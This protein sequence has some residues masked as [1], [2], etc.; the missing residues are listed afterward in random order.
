MTVAEL[1]I[2]LRALP[3]ELPAVIE[4]DGRPLEVEGVRLVDA[5]LAFV[6]PANVRGTV[7]LLD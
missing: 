3:S 6:D 2:A 4:V 1:I 5:A 7:V